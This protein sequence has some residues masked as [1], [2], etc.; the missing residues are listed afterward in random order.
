[1]S[2]FLTVLGL[3][4]TLTF[5]LESFVARRKERGREQGRQVRGVI[6]RLDKEGDAGLTTGS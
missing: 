3:V 5:G 2:V 6:G 4:A 1:M